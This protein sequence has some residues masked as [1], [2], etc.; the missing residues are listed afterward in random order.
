MFNYYNYSIKVVHYEGD[1]TGCFF[2]LLNVYSIHVIKKIYMYIRVM[3]L[4]LERRRFV[5]LNCS[6]SKSSNPT[7]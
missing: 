4:I 3:S 5:L 7:K 6:T 2:F 1:I